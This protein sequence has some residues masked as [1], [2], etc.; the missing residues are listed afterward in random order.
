MEKY[1]STGTVQ[2]VALPVRQRSARSVVN[3]AEAEASVEERSNVS[4]TRRSQVLGNSV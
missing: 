4:L 3:I 2:N 1:K